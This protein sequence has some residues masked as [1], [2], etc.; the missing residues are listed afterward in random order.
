MSTQVAIALRI[1][2][3]LARTWE[4]G[5]DFEQQLKQ[6]KHA[7]TF[8]PICRRTGRMLSPKADLK[9][10]NQASLRVVQKLECRLTTLFSI[11]QRKGEKDFS[12]WELN[13]LYKGEVRGV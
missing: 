11:A 7:E 10:L 6:Q 8:C 13:F 4:E 9:E 12:E 5:R 3:T 1:Q 2:L